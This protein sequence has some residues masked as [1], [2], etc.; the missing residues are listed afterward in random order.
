MEISVI[1]NTFNN[2]KWIER[3]LQ[4]VINQSY[5][6][7][8]CIIVD[9]CSLDNTFELCNSIRQQDSRIQL[10]RNNNNIGCSLTRKVGY[11][12]SSGDYILFIDG[13]D[14]LEDD[15]IMK[16][17]SQAKKD[18]VDLVYCD[19]YEEDGLQAKIMSQNINAKNNNQIIAAMASYDS[20]LVSSLWNKLIRRDL[21]SQIVFPPER[22]GED[23]YVSLQLAYY[24]K[25]HSYIPEALYHYWVNNKDSICNDR[26]KE[27]ERRLAMYDICTKILVFLKT[28]FQTNIQFEPYLSIRMNKTAIRIFEYSELR[29]RR[30]AYSLYPPAIKY[31]FRKEININIL[32]RLKYI[33]YFTKY[34]FS[35][36]TK[37]VLSK[38]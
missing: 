26:N 5:A 10:F 13:D 2:D 34:H 17:I 19:Y 16:M 20:Y 9:D 32:I 14:W 21:V 30:N 37:K 8:E 11:T 29:R 28:H 3:C 33:L 22:Y 12:H 36:F 18:N 6:D 4:S 31:I 38:S 24:S 1:I 15:F 23:M 25:K 27:T 7:F 35:V